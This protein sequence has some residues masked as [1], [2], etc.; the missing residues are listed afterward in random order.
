[1]DKVGRKTGWTSGIVSATCVDLPAAED[2]YW[3]DCTYQADYWSDEGDSG[4]PVFSWPGTGNDVTLVGIHW[5]NSASQQRSDFS[6][7]SGIVQDFGW[8]TVVAPEPFSNSIVNHDTY[9]YTATPTG[10]DPPY[11]SSYWEWCGIDCDGGGGGGDPAPPATRGGVRPDAIVHG[12]QFLSTDWTVYWRESQR[13]L[14]STV[15]D[16]RGQQGV[17]TYWVP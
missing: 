15:T 7:W 13:W 16:S 9:F 10:G 17:A 1:M 11:V 6:P 5:G 2:Y 4:A 8:M 3:R 12:W 14:R